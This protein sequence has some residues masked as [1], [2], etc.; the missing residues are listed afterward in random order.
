MTPSPRKQRHQLEHG[1]STVRVARRV[2]FSSAHRYHQE[3]FST[4][5]NQRVFGRCN[6]EHGHGHNYILEAFLEGPIDPQT[7]ML[8]NLIDVDHA[9]KQVTDPL[10]HQHLN[11]DIAYFKDKV[12]TTEVI[13][14]YCFRALRSQLARAFPGLN[15]QLYKVRLFEIDDLWVEYAE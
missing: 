13:A 11:F 12:P 6:T 8:V 1:G 4:A 5:E 10:D 14:Q 2:W 7:G 9:M 3:K 15:I